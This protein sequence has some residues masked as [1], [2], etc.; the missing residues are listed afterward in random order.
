MTDDQYIKE[1]IDKANKD[2][3]AVEKLKTELDMTEIVC[4]HCQ[5][6]VEK[7]LKALL[8]YNDENVQKTHN[9]DFLLNRCKTYDKE[10]EKYIGSSLSDYAVDLRYPD[11]RYIPTVEETEEAIK[12]M[13]KIIESVKKILNNKYGGYI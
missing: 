4:F 6:A 2:I 5:Q 10:L 12:L 1:W 9:I 8:I 11:T 3:K 13:Y 7:Y